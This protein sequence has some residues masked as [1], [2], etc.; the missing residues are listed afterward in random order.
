MKGRHLAYKKPLWNQLINKR[1]IAKMGEA[2]LSGI[3]VKQESLEVEN[4]MRWFKLQSSLDLE[5]GFRG[6]KQ[7]QRVRA[8]LSTRQKE[9]NMTQQEIKR[10]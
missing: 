10:D 4:P 3:Y 7:A 6:W 2:L 1:H 8:R 9:N 5:P